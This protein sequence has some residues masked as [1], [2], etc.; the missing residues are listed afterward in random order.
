MKPIILL[1]CLAMLG[2]QAS[3]FDDLEERTAFACNQDKA[4]DLPWLKEMIEQAGDQD[5][6]QVFRV[7]QGEYKGE[8]VFIPYVSGA[9]CCICG[10]AVY[11]CQGDVVFV[12]DYDKEDKI[13][14]KKTIWQQ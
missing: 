2:C 5:I 8:T 3:E 7:D 10:N 12:C 9:L 1:C 6:C 14:N 11:N 4:T 13:K